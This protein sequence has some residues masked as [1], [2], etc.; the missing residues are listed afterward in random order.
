MPNQ[1]ED[2]IWQWIPGYE[3]DPKVYQASVE[4]TAQWT[5]WQAANEA[6][7]ADPIL[8]PAAQIGTISTPTPQ[9]L[10]E[11][12]KK[13]DIAQLEMMNLLINAEIG[14]DWSSD[15]GLATS[16]L[17]A[18]HNEPGLVASI[19]GITSPETV[20]T[21]MFASESSEANDQSL[22]SGSCR[23]EIASYVPKLE[24]PLFT[25]GAR[26]LDTEHTFIIYTDE[27]GN[28]VVYAATDVNGEVWA[29]SHKVTADSPGKDLRLL[30]A[31]GHP[32]VPLAQG[33]EVCGVQLRF[34]AQVNDVNKQ[35]LS[36]FAISGPNSNSVTYYLLE[37]NDLPIQRPPYAFALPG[38]R[39][40]LRHKLST[41]IP[42]AIGVAVNPP[43]D[44]FDPYH[45]YQQ[46][47]RENMLNELRD[48]LP[49]ISLDL[50][51]TSFDEIVPNR[52]DPR[53]PWV[54]PFSPLFRPFALW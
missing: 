29:Y 34:D 11:R 23:V 42:E 8:Q 27:Y 54:D 1:V 15:L 5:L 12:V 25:F 47:Q 17:K 35:H 45:H 32:R 46:M 53:S 24:D 44:L 6:I 41:I 2:T 3:V 38:W 18:V 4:A 43:P 14:F 52:K 30:A 31:S 36:Y 22:P 33:P 40:D 16:M 49:E 50:P 20:H 9:E 19:L 39:G 21:A 26:L 51:E 13:P 10:W 48:H 28:E 37:S 7:A